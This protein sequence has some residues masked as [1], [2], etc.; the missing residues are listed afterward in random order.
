MLEAL[1]Q[2]IDEA[3]DGDREGQVG[4]SG[5]RLHPRNQAEE[6]RRQNKHEKRAEERDVVARPMTLQHPGDKTVKPLGQDLTHRTQR[7]STFG[8]AWIG[9]GHQGVSRQQSENDQDSH[10]DPG[11]NQDR[12]KVQASRDAVDEIDRIQTI[13][14]ASSADPYPVRAETRQVSIKIAPGCVKTP[15]TKPGTLMLVR[16]R[17][18]ATTGT[19]NSNFNGAATIPSR[20]APP[21]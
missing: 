1:I 6:I 19:I 17:S 21:L 5:R 8:D 4:V 2:I 3:D 15:S 13:A 10:R 7:D 18:Q 14:S 9:R 16:L 12:R 20:L 11:S